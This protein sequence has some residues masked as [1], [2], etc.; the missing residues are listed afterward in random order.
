MEE[1][2]KEV[3]CARAFKRELIANF[4]LIAVAVYADISF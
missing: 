1:R 2:E 4:I 3:F